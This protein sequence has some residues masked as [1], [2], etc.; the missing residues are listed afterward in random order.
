MLFKNTT[1]E[2]DISVDIKK[3][4]FTKYSNHSKNREFNTVHKKKRSLFKANMFW[5]IPGREV[6]K[7]KS[8][9]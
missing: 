4:V 3:N 5:L 7:E 1:P 9:C 8:Y 6:K 2:N